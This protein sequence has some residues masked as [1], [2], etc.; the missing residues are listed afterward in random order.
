MVVSLYLCVET[1]YSPS[2]S[3]FTSA[4]QHSPAA[5]SPLF[6]L[7]FP[8]FFSFF[9]YFFVSR[10]SGSMQSA[11]FPLP[12]LTILGL[13]WGNAII[14]SNTSGSWASLHSIPQHR[15]KIQ[16]KLV[17]NTMDFVFLHN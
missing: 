1:V 2:E 14:I 10:S 3:S 8:I 6:A 11:I 7:V 13:S 5:P 15:G 17:I 16:T 12:K 9:F 4:P